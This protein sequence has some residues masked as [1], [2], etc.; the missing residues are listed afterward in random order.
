[1]KIKAKKIMSWAIIFVMLLSMLQC[2]SVD[3]LAEDGYTPTN[4]YVL[5]FGAHAS[6]VDVYA[7]FSRLVPTLTY[8]GKTVDG[9]S[10]IFGLT[11]DYNNIDFQSLYCTDM[12]VDATEGSYYQRL[13]L[14]DSTY[15]GAVAN[16]LRGVLLGTYPHITVEKLVENS[17]IAGLTKSEAIVGSQLAIW[18]LAHGDNVKVTDF[19]GFYG[20]YVSAGSSA[21]Q[22]ELDNEGAA[23]LASSPEEQAASKQ[24]IEQLYHYLLN[25][26]QVAASKTVASS[27]SFVS[28][29]ETPTVTDN[30]DG[31]FDVTVATT[32]NVQLDGEDSLTLTAHMSDGK[33]YTSQPLSNGSQ[34]YTLTIPNVPA[35]N[36][37]DTVTLAIDGTQ[38]ASDV[39][40]VDAD[41]I[42]GVSQSMIGVLDGTLPVHA[43]TDVS[44]DRVLN[45]QK[46]DGNGYG[47]ENI[48]FD[49]YY[50]GSLDAYLDGTLGIGTKPTEADIAKYADAENL[51]GTLTTDANGYASLNFGTQDGVY[52]VKELQNDAISGTI[53]PFFVTLPDYSRGEGDSPAYTITAQPKNTVREENIDIKKDV[54]KIDNEEDTYDVGEDHSW[55]I[56]TSVPRT[57]S[58]G[59]AYTITDTLDARLTYQKIEKVVLADENGDEVLTLT[60]ER[61]YTV[62]HE[63]LTETE[64][65]H[66]TVSLTSQGMK[67]VAQKAGDNYE[68]YELRTYLVAK[69][70]QKAIMGEDIPNKAYISFTNNVGKSYSDESDM[71]K[72]HTGGVQLKKVDQRDNE[73]VL[74]GA[75]FA[76]Y[77]EATNEDLL[78]EVPYEEFTIGETTRKLIKVSFYPTSDLTGEKGDSLTTDE[79]G[80]GY[81]YGLAYGEYY[82]VETEAPAGY[83]KPLEPIAF[84]VDGNSHLDE[85][86]IVVE[87][88]AG[89]EL[90]STGGVGTGIFT[91]LGLCLV[92]GASVVLITR[93]RM[94]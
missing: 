42:R 66:I 61:D 59:K 18:Q 41:G 71:P 4:P 3:V 34:T 51:V 74:S 25:L 20:R 45:I 63:K 13:N 88:Y 58:S 5:S 9:Y 84:T 30:G 50:V 92:I 57:L 81:I 93:K 44:P 86:V 65:D 2:V 6:S 55:I 1:M 77:R 36:A 54:T 46:T 15:A 64:Q 53:D 35:A 78:A 38:Y 31:T 83:R 40:L 16:R 62:S 89:T 28:K 23:Y 26:P 33:Y 43:E 91:G 32:V 11:D 29:S 24:R 17:G 72:I 75:T 22:K 90:P 73:V 85:N 52:L 19:I 48:S 60:A 69:I 47:L 12:P 8:N 37:G 21:E 27:A 68:N 94:A 87:N 82:L 76:V 80:M 70:N 67:T 49:V 7:Q 39:Y 14:E 56:R 79:Y 10:I